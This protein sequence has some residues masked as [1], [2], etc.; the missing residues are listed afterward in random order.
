MLHGLSRYT[1]L[2]PLTL[3]L[4]SCASD[5]TQTAN[6]AAL[7]PA[8]K[9][10]NQPQVE[11]STSPAVAASEAN[12]LGPDEALAQIPEAMRPVTLLPEL[13]AKL[14][15][16]DLNNQG[17]AMFSDVATVASGADITFC[18]YIAGATAQVMHIHDTLGVQSKFGHHAI[19]QYTTQPQAPGTRPCDPE[20]LEA[21][22]GQIIGGTGGEGTGAIVLPSNIVSE[23]PAGSQF[24][25]NHHWINWGEEPIEVQAEMVTVPPNS[26]DALRIARA[27]SIVVA[28]FNVPP[29]ELGERSGEC[30]F[31]EDMGMLSMLGH[32][33]RWGTHVKAERMGDAPDVIFDHNY[34]ESMV[35][36]PVT[37]NYPVEAPYQFRKG[38]SV[39][40]A[41]QW[42]NTSAEAL[43]FPHEM[44]ILFGWRLG[45]DRD[46]TCLGGQWL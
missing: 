5:P 41:C 12:A 16:P 25:I 9:P 24:I 36:H 15:L 8:Q 18:S 43:T 28:D 2:L 10:E 1:A 30:V 17:I 21:Q 40:M 22:Q 3:S 7:T 34:D 29:K 44:C 20:S 35:S 11:A 38:E 46:M 33:H 23:V 45:G 32:Q 13:K 37:N 31:P 4:F 39:R 26:G 19:M 42:Q 14:L 6:D 27:V